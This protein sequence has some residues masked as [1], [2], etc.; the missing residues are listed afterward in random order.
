MIGADALVQPASDELHFPVHRGLRG[1]HDLGGL[2][3]RASE[4]V[5]EL[6]ELNLS[7]IEG[8]QVIQSAVEVDHRLSADLHP[9]NL[10]VQ[11]NMHRAAASPQ[12]ILAAGV[13]RQNPAHHF[14][15]EGIE[16]R[17]IHPVHFLLADEAQVDLVNQGGGL[18]YPRL[19]LSANI[20]CRNLPQVRVHQ[21][22][23]LLKGFGVTLLPF[24]QEQCYLT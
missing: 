10:F 4:E 18:Q 9:R 16:V 14:G 1:P 19:S 17:S 8:L 11:R 22:H 6:D 3:R 12:G 7:R 21:R 23:Q 13:I 15:R 5:S 24:L 20:C 2:F